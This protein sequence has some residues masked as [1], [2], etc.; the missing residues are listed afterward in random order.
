M[1]ST[2]IIRKIDDLGRIVIP[3]EI[4]KTLS[5]KDGEDI[6]I[7]IE[8][9][10]IILKKHHKLLGFKEKVDN[11]LNIFQKYINGNIFVLDRE[12][13]ITST[14]KSFENISISKNLLNMIE[15]RKKVVNNEN[16][17]LDISNNYKINNKFI[18]SP[19]IINTDLLGAIL[20]V[21][22]NPITET[23]LLITTILSTLIKF[24]MEN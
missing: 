23:D 7:F 19:I 17:L 10:M 8:E 24:E 22:E 2:G 18:L 14:D 6:E 5:I 4:R 21:F 16:V 1:K 20:I 12:K 13:I 3:K 9:E 15:E 11:L